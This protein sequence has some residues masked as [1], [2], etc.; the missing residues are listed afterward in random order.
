[1][2]ELLKIF[3]EWE[4]PSILHTDNGSEFINE[5]IEALDLIWKD[6]L[7]LHGKP[8]RPWVQGS[9]ERLNRTTGVMVSIWLSERETVNF[10][11]A[12]EIGE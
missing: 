2:I 11:P 12:F 8:R 4:C 10:L 3:R 5:L 6:V 1:M 9:V 7:I